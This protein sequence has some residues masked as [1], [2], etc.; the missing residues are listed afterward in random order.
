VLSLNRVFISVSSLFSSPP[1]SVTLDTNPLYLKNFKEDV[2]IL[3][4]GAGRG[5]ISD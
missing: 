1:S 3:M 5:W 4:A 2:E